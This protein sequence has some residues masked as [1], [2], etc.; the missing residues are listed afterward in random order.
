MSERSTGNKLRSL[1][2]ALV[3][4]G[5]V[6]AVGE[7]RGQQRKVPGPAPNLGGHP[8]PNVG[9][10]SNLAGPAGKGPSPNTGAG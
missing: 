7:A 10:G 8:M 3:V 5:L 6:L 4:P 9:P 1:I 2:A